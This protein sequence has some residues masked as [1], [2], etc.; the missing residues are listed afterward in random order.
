MENQYNNQNNIN[1][2]QLP[3]I[4]NGAVW[5]V[6]ILPALAMFL[7]AFAVNKYLGFLLWGFVLIASP[8]ICYYDMK[9]LEKYGVDVHA[10]KKYIFLIPVIYI[11]TRCRILRQSNTKAVMY[12][13]F[14]VFALFGNG[15][16]RSLQMTNQDFIDNV[17]QNYVV[18]LED[19]S[20][21]TS[22]NV[23]GTQIKSFVKGNEVKYKIETK[24][25]LR[26]VTASG[27]CSYDKKDNQ[28][29]D[30][31]FELNYDGYAFKSFK[32]DSILINGEKLNDEKKE[33]LMKE[34]FLEEHKEKS[35]KDASSKSD[36]SSS[37]EDISSKGYV[38]V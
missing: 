38:Q 7:E 32:V 37:K 6:A 23:I 36:Q 30:I 29:I 20:G 22:M 2:N 34:I 24:D 28:K 17:K 13:V 15:F 3:K 16:T 12:V 21:Q 10:F 14:A 31:I 25:N 5:Y 18:N 35:K 11:Y 19:F 33:K 8:I 27:V 4:R 26:Y 1:L 9:T